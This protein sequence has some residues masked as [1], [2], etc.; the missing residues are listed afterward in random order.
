MGSSTREDDEANDVDPSDF[1]DMMKGLHVPGPSQEQQDLQTFLEAQEQIKPWWVRRTPKVA[2]TV[3][4]ISRFWSKLVLTS[5]KSEAKF[6]VKPE[7]VKST[8]KAILQLENEIAKKKFPKLNFPTA[9]ATEKEAVQPILGA[10]LFALCHRFQMIVLKA[11]LICSISV[12][13]QQLCLV[14]SIA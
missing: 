14:Q 9:I 12:T 10:L 2:N 8:V 6:F 5:N 11:A 13:C 1:L 7:K 4:L 3:M